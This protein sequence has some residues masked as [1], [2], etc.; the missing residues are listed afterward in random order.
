MLVP[1]RQRETDI[2]SQLLSSGALAQGAGAVYTALSTESWSD[3]ER[4]DARR[5]AA[6]NHRG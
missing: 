2:L 6:T 5:P 4:R 3:E 1:L